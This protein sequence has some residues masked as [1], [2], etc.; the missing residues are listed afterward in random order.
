MGFQLVQTE[1]CSPLGFVVKER[2]TAEMYDIWARLILPCTA[3]YLEFLLR[4]QW[5]NAEVNNESSLQFWCMINSLLSSWFFIPSWSSR[6]IGTNRLRLLLVFLSFTVSILFKKQTSERSVM[7]YQFSIFLN[8]VANVHWFFEMTS[9]K[10]KRSRKNVP[11]S[12][13]QLIWWPLDVS[14]IKE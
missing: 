9:D 14:I 2:F 11:G 1:L 10:G 6:Y 8:S 5:G 4:N 13:R 12:L 7:Y 3:E